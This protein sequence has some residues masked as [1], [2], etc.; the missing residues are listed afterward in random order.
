MERLP[1]LLR[2]EAAVQPG[3]PPGHA[4]I[5]AARRLRLHR[6]GRARRGVAPSG[7]GGRVPRRRRRLAGDAA[8]RRPRPP[9]RRRHPRDGAVPP[10]RPAHRSKSRACPR[11]TARRRARRR[12]ARRDHSTRRREE[13]VP[14]LADVESP[15]AAARVGR[16]PLRLG[17][18]LRRLPL[19]A[20]DHDRAEGQGVGALGVLACD[21]AR[22]LRRKALDRAAHADPPA[23]LRRPPR[24][25]A[26]RP[27]RRGR[28]T[29]PGELAEGRRRGRGAR[30]QPP[31]RAEHA[32][33]LRARF[34]RRGVLAGRHRHV[35]AR[36]RARRAVH[37]VGLLA[38][39]DARA[40]C[41][42]DRPPIPPR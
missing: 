42:G 17:R 41:G 15:Q 34:R 14:A 32:R 6:R 36:A 7:R 10:C 1:G 27:A 37:G 28:S 8:L 35:A 39:A 29:R 20:Q 40:A 16:R 23:A 24:P 31:R 3:V 21:D 38:A 5:A 12:R 18:E 25:D 11:S 22:R 19:A 33:R 9:A 13:R 30:G 2:G 26:G 4:R